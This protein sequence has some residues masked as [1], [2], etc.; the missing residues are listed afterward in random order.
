MP[1]IKLA[2]SD[3]NTDEI[4]FLRGGS[5]NCVLRMYTNQTAIENYS[6]SS[7][8]TNLAVTPDYSI[9]VVWSSDSTVLVMSLNNL[10]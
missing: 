10:T 5:D 6:L 1:H 4:V 8:F 9:V 3:E 2:V 7:N